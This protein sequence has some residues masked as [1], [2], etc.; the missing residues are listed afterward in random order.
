MKS[1]FKRL[2]FDGILYLANRV[3]ARMPSHTLRLLFYRKCMRFEIGRPS[4]I[5][6]DAWFDS[7]GQFA[8]GKNSVINQKCRLDNRGGL[9]IGDN[10]SISSEVVI[11]TAD[12]NLQSASFA[13]RNCPVIIEDYVFIGTR[14][15]IL[16]G[17]TLGRGCAVGAGSVVTKDVPANSI[18]AGIPAKQIGVRKCEFQYDIYYP[19][20]FS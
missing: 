7:Q 16:P 18:V 8:I 20:L 2:H 13:G 9:Y 6:M 10:V 15:M 3:V 17:V 14:A 4:L 5:F 12:H 11:L 1:F 19:R